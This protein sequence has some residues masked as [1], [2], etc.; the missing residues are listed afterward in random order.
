MTTLV[1]TG[2]GLEITN[3]MQKRAMELMKKVFERYPPV[4][5]SV[6][7]KQSNRDINISIHYHDN[8]AET[9][10][11]KDHS[12]FYLGMKLTRDSL[13]KSLKSHHGTM[14]SS[15]RT[16]INLVDAEQDLD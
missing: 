13:L 6:T 3:V 15:R 16:R 7:V 2:N 14:K 1:I 11:S 10:V 12:D 4:S 9:H 8:I 5:H